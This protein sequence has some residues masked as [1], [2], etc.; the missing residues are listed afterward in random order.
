M[1]WVGKDHN[2]H[3]FQPPAMCQ[4]APQADQSHIYPDLECL[5]GWGIHS[6]LG[7]PLQCVTTPWVKNFLLISNPNLPRLR[8]G[9]DAA[10][11]ELVFKG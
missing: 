9:G 8:E 1:A 3:Q 11:A 6:L 4:L 7:Q 5:Q 2:D 10:A